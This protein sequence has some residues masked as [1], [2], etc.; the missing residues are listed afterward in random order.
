VR[1]RLD[2]EGEAATILATNFQLLENFQL[3][4]N[5]AQVQE[6][7]ASTKQLE[8]MVPALVKIEGRD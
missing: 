3:L 7:L 8:C 4:A 6:L 2:K 5:P 1:V